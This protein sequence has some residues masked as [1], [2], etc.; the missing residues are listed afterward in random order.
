MG[1]L[2]LNLIASVW[3][4][5]SIPAGAQQT[6]YCCDDERGRP[7]CG[8]VL[9]SACFGKAYREISPQGTVR[10][11]VAAPLTPEEIAVR[12][13][14]LRLQQEEEARLAAQRRVDRALLETYQNLDEI[15]FLE[16][17]ALAEVDREIEIIAQREEELAEQRQRLVLETEFYVGRELPREISTGL[18]LIDTELAAYQS[19][20]DAKQGEKEAIRERFAVDRRRYA[21]LIASGEGRRR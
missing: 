9:P 2:R 21:E 17:R 14:A 13:E 4:L 1:L 7:M 10:R 19:V 15:D 11:H 20:R 5:A 8:D 18:R 12:D 6:I 3:L 16:A